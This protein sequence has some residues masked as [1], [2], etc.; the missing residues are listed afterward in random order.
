MLGF[1]LFGHAIGPFLKL[2]LYS[3]RPHV[4]LPKEINFDHPTSI[5]GNGNYILEMVLGRA[6]GA[7][8]VNEIF[9]TL[10]SFLS[11]CVFVKHNPSHITSKKNYCILFLLPQ[12]F[13]IGLPSLLPQN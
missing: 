7:E 9:L 12:G 13:Q 6:K 10:Y 4:Y 8:K 2:L 3:R 1:T 11:L 5:L